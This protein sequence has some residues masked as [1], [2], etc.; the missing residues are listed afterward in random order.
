MLIRTNMEHQSP[1]EY[2]DNLGEGE[3]ERFAEDEDLYHRLEFER[4]LQ[5]LE[6]WLPEEGRILDAGGAAGRYSRWLAEREY[7]VDLM[8]ISREQLLIADESVVPEDTVS[9]S[10]QS[11]T[12]I[13]FADDSFDAVLCTGGPLSHVIDGEEREEAVRELIRVAKPQSPVFVSVMGLLNVL[14]LI[15]RNLPEYDESVIMEELAETGEYTAEL[16]SQVDFEVGQFTE[17]KFFRV[18]EFED[19][20]ESNGLIVKDIVPLEAFTYGVGGLTAS[21]EEN[22]RASISAL[23]DDKYVADISPHILAVGWVESR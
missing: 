21:Q 17:S 8:D 7:T 1:Q 11:I 16:A 13:A 9:I 23:P 15:S 4:T 22:V 10:Q 3:F 20:L 5:T 12:D 14:G 19:L 18:E 6:D 2:Y